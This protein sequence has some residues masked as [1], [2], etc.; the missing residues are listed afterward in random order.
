MPLEGALQPS[1][2]QQLMASTQDLD[3]P[4]YDCGQGLRCA[5][6]AQPGSC[7]IAASNFLNTLR[8]R[9]WTRQGE[10]VGPLPAARVRLR[11]WNH[12]DR[13][14]PAER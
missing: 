12:F 2:L 7:T 9:E 1:F 3:R 10:A 8:L 13:R 6:F 14:S 4:G 11:G 5:G